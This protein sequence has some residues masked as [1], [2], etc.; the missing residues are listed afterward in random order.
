MDAT[1]Q[2]RGPVIGTGFATLVGWHLLLAAAALIWLQRQSD[3]A[4][5]GSGWS[6]RSGGAL[7]LIFVGVP[8]LAG[9]ALVGSLVVAALTAAGVRSG[10]LAGIGGSAVGLVAVVVVVLIRFA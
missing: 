2:S 10:V 3:V 5:G 9:S 7:A 6:D 8:A 1:R 4:D